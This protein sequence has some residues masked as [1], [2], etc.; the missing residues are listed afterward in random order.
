MNSSQTQSLRAGFRPVSLIALLAGVAAVA[1][2]AVVAFGGGGGRGNGNGGV[3][4][5]SG[6]PAAP[7]SAPPSQAPTEAPSD[8]PSADPTNEPTNEPTDEPTNEPDPGS[9]GMPIKVDLGNATGADVY[10][11]IVDQTGRLSGARSGTPGDGASVE[12]RTLR[13]ENLDERTL[14]LTWIDYPIDNALALYIEDF[15][16]HLRLLL[17]QPEPT[18]ATD[19]MG[20][21]RE[22][23]LSFSESVSADEVEAILTEG[24]DTPG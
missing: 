18:G 8:E 13:V 6:S 16:G 9:D 22:L 20:F 11:D 17:V 4:V 12:G 24:L 7:P 2:V 21:D 14:K 1:V 10:V 3:A 23:I 19:A 15:E 5:P